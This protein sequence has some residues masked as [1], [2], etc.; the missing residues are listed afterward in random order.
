MPP[1]PKVPLLR[2][3]TSVTSGAGKRKRRQ[4]RESSHKRVNLTI[5]DVDDP[6]SG[7][8]E[9][10]DSDPQYSDEIV[11][12][13]DTAHESED[14]DFDPHHDLALEGP[15]A[16]EEEEKPKPLLR[17]KYHT[18]TVSGYCLCVV[19]EPW[20]PQRRIT[21]PLSTALLTAPSHDDI[22]TLVV[23]DALVERGRTPLFFPELDDNHSRKPEGSSSVKARPPP[24]LL[25]SSGEADDESR[26]GD[27][28]MNFSQAL[29]TTGYA[30]TGSIDDEDMEGAVLFGDADEVR[31]LI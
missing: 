25:D 15:P 21:G 4:D 16:D 23:E 10:D 22:G 8:S 28:L 11:D 14:D 19:V 26:R 2:A 12:Q 24:F 13:P 29:N 31:E 30:A 18:L 9:D 27:T 5:D 1:P 6:M 17:L 3:S 20:S 7:A